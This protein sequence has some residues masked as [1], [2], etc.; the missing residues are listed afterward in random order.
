MGQNIGSNL[1]S[2]T[3]HNTSLRTSGKVHRIAFIEPIDFSVGDTKTCYDTEATCP[4][5]QERDFVS[6][7]NSLSSKKFGLNFQLAIC[8][9]GNLYVAS[10]KGMV[11][12]PLSKG[13]TYKRM[14][15]NYKK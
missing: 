8:F 1:L 12:L 6:Y 3:G 10:A 4:E 5:F 11:W 9:V 2:Q 13:S 14:G 7:W 15:G